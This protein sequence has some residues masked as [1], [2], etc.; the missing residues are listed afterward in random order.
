MRATD[1]RR[2]SAGD[3]QTD[4]VDEASRE[5]FPASD[6]P[7]YTPPTGLGPPAEAVPEDA[8]AK[9]PPPAPVHE[10]PLTDPASRAA[11]P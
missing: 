5:S 7:S 4:I 9:V 2:P 3:Q 8:A 1:G 10:D 6:P 11:P